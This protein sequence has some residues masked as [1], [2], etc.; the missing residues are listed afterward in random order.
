MSEFSA[1]I[2]LC[3]N[4][5]YLA[6][7]LPSEIGH[8]GASAFCEDE[9]VILSLKELGNFLVVLDKTWLQSVFE[10]Q[11]QISNVVN[12]LLSQLRNSLL[13]VEVS[14]LAHLFI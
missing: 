8:E 14:N 9:N 12:Y 10:L 2:C 1:G 3:M 5:R 7:L 11:T 6:K 4:V 13:L